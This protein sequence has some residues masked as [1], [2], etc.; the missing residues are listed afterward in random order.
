MDFSQRQTAEG[1][2][3]GDD[4]YKKEA[5]NAGSYSRGIPQGNVLEWRNKGVVERLRKKLSIR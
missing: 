1:R 4:I 3:G 2:R 5:R